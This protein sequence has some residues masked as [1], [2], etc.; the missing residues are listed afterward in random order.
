MDGHQ[1]MNVIRARTEAWRLVAAT[2]IAAAAMVV[3]SPGALAAPGDLDRSFSRDGKTHPFRSLNGEQVWDM[4]IADLPAGGFVLYGTA[5]SYAGPTSSHVGSRALLASYRAN[6][7]LRRSF[8][9][10]GETVTKVGRGIRVSVAQALPD[11]RLVVAGVVARG[12]DALDFA[13]LRFTRDGRLDKAFGEDGAVIADLLP[14]DGNQYEIP[15]DLVIAPDGSI[16]VSG[17]ASP[18]PTVGYLARYHPD[19]SLDTSFSEDGLLTLEGQGYN[20]LELLPDGRFYATGGLSLTRF[21]S[22]GR[23]DPSFSD[24]GVVT[25]PG[26]IQ[27]SSLTDPRADEHGRVWVGLA[28]NS[29]GGSCGG[30]VWRFDPA[31]APDQAFSGDGLQAIPVGCGASVSL[32][33]DGAFVVTRGL[34]SVMGGNKLFVSRIQQ[35]GDFDTSFSEDGRVAVPYGDLLV[36]SGFGPGARLTVVYRDA[37]PAKQTHERPVLTMVRYELS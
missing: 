2:L 20:G 1:W 36:G 18:Y 10:N 19:G 22:D 25:V 6:G 14:G 12:K 5:D 31:G 17:V 21:T 30:S 24:D 11:G 32:T 13:L 16:L 3:L 7:K 15:S 23:P 27:F 4:G 8:G 26:Q 33:G 9:K 29:V 37:I 35:S 28:S 34:Q